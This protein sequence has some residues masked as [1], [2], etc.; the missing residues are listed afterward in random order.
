MPS[1]PAC[2]T[3][4]ARRVS[5]AC[6]KCYTPVEVYAGHWFRKGTGSPSLAVL[7][8]FEKLVS[9]QLS[10]GRPNKVLFS[11]PPF[12]ARYKRELV[13]AERLLM[14]ANWDIDLVK[15]ALDV[16]FTDHRYAWKTR[17]TM[18]YIEAEFNTALAIARA[19]LEL[20]TQAAAN[21]RK[22]L[23]GILQRENIFN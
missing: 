5:G 21:E 9:D 7:R 23:E 8:Y 20:K 10:S 4:Q 3:E 1:C 13:V 22:A 6:P 12:G 14:L 19:N 2:H 17:N 11:I 18:L 16:L 15:A